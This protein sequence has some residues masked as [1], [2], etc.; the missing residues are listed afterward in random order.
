[1]A[2]IVHPRKFQLDVEAAHESARGCMA[3]VYSRHSWGL[4]AAALK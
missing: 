2:E 4:E 3:S 1:M